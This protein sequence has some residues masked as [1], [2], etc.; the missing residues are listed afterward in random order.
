VALCLLVLLV[1]QAIALQQ[2]HVA[3]LLLQQ[4][5]HGLDC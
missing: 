5:T 1:L 2:L 4:Q 3:L